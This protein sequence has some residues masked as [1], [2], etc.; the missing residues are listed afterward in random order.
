PALVS[1]AE[2]I[3]SGE[4]TW[5]S[6]HA[7]TVGSP[8]SWFTDPFTGHAIDHTQHWSLIPDF[9]PAAAD[10][11]CIWE[12][13]RFHWALTLARAAR[14]TGDRRYL[15]CLNMWTLDWQRLNPPNTGPNWKCGQEASIRVITVLLASAIVGQSEA[16]PA[17]LVRFVRTHIDRIR[18]TMSYAIAQDN[19]HGTSEAA[20]MFIAGAW[21]A[22]VSPPNAAR[23]R[24]WE[25]LGRARLEERALR[26][27]SPDGSFSQHSTNYHRL[28]LD[29]L[30]MAEWW[31]R[32][33]ARPAFSAIFQERTRAAARWLFEMVDPLSGDAP[34]IGANDGAHEYVLHSRPYR[35]HRPSVQLAF[36][37]FD[38][39]LPFEGADCD[40]PLHWLGL[41]HLPASLVERTSTLFRAG[42]YITLHPPSRRLRSWAAIRL[43]AFTFR[44]AHADALHLDLWL[45][46]ENLL[47]DGGSLSYASG[48]GCLL[49]TVACHN[50]VQFD[51]HDQMP[52]LSRFL[53]GDWLRPAVVGDIE[54]GP[55]GC[56]WSGAYVDAFGCR[57]RRTVSTDGATWRIA[58]EFSG[59]SRA[60]LRWRLAPGSWHLDRA[61]LSCSSDLA[62][63]SVQT[64][65]A[66][67]RLEL[68]EGIESRHYM[69]R[70]PLPVL[71]C[72]VTLDTQM[73]QILTVASV[74][75]RV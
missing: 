3:L 33:L 38:G 16:P 23:A 18:P 42:G 12:P 27:V 32:R 26:L 49:G 55:E 30:S 39:T 45:G 51:G 36:A 44:P 61:S 28:L 59:A 40:E 8:P 71:E 43:P 46:G 72:E 50:T 19:N 29:T 11:K 67:H 24:R 63:L 66:V 75:D 48:D 5:F 57:H 20:A 9:D 74:K 56:S 22:T 64:S 62:S 34:V 13:S 47:R 73:T 41:P 69:E 7:F 21:L 17:G 68:V 37:L 60:V 58:D 54:T 2:A 1:A 25:R 70:T 65:A 35:D 15:E 53:Y 31:R 6:H 10:I 14:A 4:L 52:L